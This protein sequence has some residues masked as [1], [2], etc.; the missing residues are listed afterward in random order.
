M[1]I[2]WRYFPTSLVESLFPRGNDAI[3]DGLLNETEDRKVRLQTAAEVC[4]V[5]MLSVVNRLPQLTRGIPES[6]LPRNGL[7]RD[8]A[9]LLGEL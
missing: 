7:Y 3:A 9:R 1:T 4:A 8:S 5:E 6:H 2:L